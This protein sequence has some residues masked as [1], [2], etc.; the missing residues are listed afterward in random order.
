TTEKTIAD[1]FEPKLTMTETIENMPLAT[2]KVTATVG[3]PR[4]FVVGVYMALHPDSDPNPK[5]DDPAFV[6]VRNEQ[7]DRVKRSVE[8]IVMADDSASV[9][10]DVYPDMDWSAEGSAW[11][12]APGGIAAS[13]PSAGTADTLGMIRLYGPQA[14]LA[15][16][17]LMSLVMMMRMVRKSSEVLG[18]ARAQPAEPRKEPDAEELLTVGGGPIG[19]AEV[20]QS[21]LA[22]QEVEPEALRY[23]E[24][25]EEVAK[26]VEQDSEGTARLFQQWIEDND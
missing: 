25:G 18:A 26:M 3:I 6:V 4:S 10:V 23:Q 15:G 1:Y 13:L 5:D 7:I 20:S 8:L 9:A 19:Q 21:L 2:S 11:S 22:G 14:A 17:A 16:F 12:R 24:H